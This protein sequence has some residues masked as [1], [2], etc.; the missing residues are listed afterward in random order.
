METK[1]ETKENKRKYVVA[2]LGQLLA[3]SYALMGQLHLAHWNVEGPSFFTLHVAFQTQY[4]ELLPAIDDIAERIRAL[5]ALTPGGLATLAKASSVEELAVAHLPARDYVAHLMKS[6]EV[7]AA[8]AEALR[9]AAGEAGDVETEDM[10]I[11]RVQVHQKTLW[12]LR[13]FLKN[14]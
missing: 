8:S 2:A 13:S 6:H 5:D 12:M 4:E 9:D 10:A 1:T 7:V 11:A 14:M 3:D